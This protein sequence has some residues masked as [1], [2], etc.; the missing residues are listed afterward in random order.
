[1]CRIPIVALIASSCAPVLVMADM[2]PAPVSVSDFN[3][4]TGD[5]YLVRGGRKQPYHGMHESWV[6]N[7]AMVWLDRQTG[8]DDAVICYSSQSPLLLTGR[9]QVSRWHTGK[10]D[11][12]ADV[13]DRFTRFVKRDPQWEF[14]HV[15]LPSFQFP[16]EQHPVAE[17]EVAEATHPWQWLIVVKGRSGPPLYA[18][19]WQTAPGKLTVNLLDLYRNKGYGQHFANFHFFVA[20]WTKDPKQEAKVVFR[21][22]LD[23]RR[24]IVP[25]LPVIR[26]HDRATNEGIPIHAVVLDEK[27]KRLGK[28]S[29]EVTASLGERTFELVDSGSGIWKA[30]V[31]GVPVGEHKATLRAVWKADRGKT[32]ASTLSIHVTDGQFVGYDPKLRLLTQRG[33]P[34]GPI[35][36]SHRT[37]VMFKSIGTPRESLLFGQA[38]WEAALAADGAPDYGFHW[39]ESFTEGELDADFAYLARCGWSALHQSQGWMWWERLDCGG[40]IAPYGAEQLALLLAAARRNQVRV[41]FSLSLYPYGEGTPTWA[42]YYEAGYQKSDYSKPDSKFYQMFADYIKH[43][44]T[45]FRDETALFALNATGES[46]FLASVG[47]PFVNHVYDLLQAH[48]GNHLVICEP[49][50]WLDKDP[51]YYRKTGWKP[52]LGGMRTYRIE[53][54]MPTAVEPIAVLFKLAALGDLFMAEGLSWLHIDPVTKRWRGPS[55]K[56]GTLEDPVAMTHYRER[57]RETFYTGLAYRTAALVSWD[58]R[59]TEDERIIFEQVRRAV[60]WSKPFQTPRLAIRLG[61]GQVPL[62]GRSKLHAYEKALSSLPLECTYVWQDDPVPPGTLFTIDARQVPVEPA[63]V[64]ASSPEFVGEFGFG[65]GSE[66][67]I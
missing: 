51:N 7:R 15:T 45:I 49:F 54:T 29:V 31:R 60:D 23:G 25:S 42:Q 58:E 19:P 39:W 53:W 37:Q 27:A 50:L 44:A 28:E 21:L 62:R 33:K 11:E 2:P 34:L 24:A 18:S 5:V 35:A 32:A 26:T 17:L 13:D 38:E 59:V 52:V 9:K 10:A 16:I 57:I 8:V 20:T 46:D 64:S 41:Y 30:V 65:E 48:D 14:D 22:H 67:V 40:R 3:N 36:G 61:P 1:M 43:F 63:F 6:F 47:K 55:Q 56:W 12:L 4:Y 66:V